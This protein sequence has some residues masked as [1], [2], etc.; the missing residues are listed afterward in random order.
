[1]IFQGKAQWRDG[2]KDLIEDEPLVFD[3]YRVDAVCMHGMVVQYKFVDEE[4]GERDAAQAA[5]A[6]GETGEAACRCMHF[7]DEEGEE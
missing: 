3:D 5:D 2:P 7:V 6:F 4:H 1:M